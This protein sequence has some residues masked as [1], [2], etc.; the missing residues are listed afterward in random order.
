MKSGV[1]ILLI[2]TSIALNAQIQFEQ[3]YFINNAGERVD[4]WIK[5]AEWQY[6]PIQFQYRFSESSAIQTLEKDSI[7]EIGIGR[8]AKWVK[9]KVSIDRSGD[10]L[11]HLS[12]KL[13]AEWN[14]E[15][16]LLRVLVEGKANLFLYRDRNITRFFFSIDSNPIEQL[17]YKKYFTSSVEA[18]ENKFYLMQL[19]QNINCEGVENV[20]VEYSSKELIRYF[21][22]YNDC[23]NEATY[24]YIYEKGI[25]FNLKVATGLNYS[26]L[27][28]YNVIGFTNVEI[29]FKNKLNFRFGMEME[30]ILPFNKGKWGI[31]VEPTY[32]SYNSEIAQGTI[33]S[34]VVY[35]SIE[36][37]IGLRHYFFIDDYSKLFLNLTYIFDYPINS[38]IK[39]VT[40]ILEIDSDDNYALGFGYVNRK[41]SMELRY[42]SIR[43]VLKNYVAWEN[44]YH[45]YS[46][47]IGYKLF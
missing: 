21:K 16:L 28:I 41:L 12:T 32:R 43:N 10:N 35:N 37:P 3:G 15:I 34:S 42:H 6:N 20:E 40:S 2:I 13:Q 31:V 11:K 18:N 46:V 44:Y 5:N 23:K 9:V 7:T 38:E 1:T 36:I 29:N 14:E 30:F 4:V 45:N 26:R 22:K 17:L 25:D 39:A 33:T 8:I 19:Q 24:V 27:S 47:I